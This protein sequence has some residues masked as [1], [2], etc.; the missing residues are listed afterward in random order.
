MLTNA[1]HLSPKKRTDYGDRTAIRGETLVMSLCFPCTVN[2]L[3]SN[4]DTPHSH[5]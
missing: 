4:I 5:V 3:K 2:P 1:V